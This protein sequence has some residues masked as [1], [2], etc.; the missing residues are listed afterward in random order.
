MGTWNIENVGLPDIANF[1]VDGVRRRTRGTT[2]IFLQAGLRYT[3]RK[4]KDN[5]LLPSGFAFFQGINLENSGIAG[6]NQIEVLTCLLQRQTPNTGQ[7]PNPS[8]K[9]RKVNEKVKESI[10]NKNASIAKQ[11]TKYLSFLGTNCLRSK[12]L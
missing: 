11:K 7:N 3:G 1:H 4:S 5:E 2:D 10:Q 9:K 12:H 8:L 6:A